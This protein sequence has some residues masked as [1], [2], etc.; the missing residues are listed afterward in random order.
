M[1]DWEWFW[2]R[3]TD[4]KGYEHFGPYP[5]ALAAEREKEREMEKQ[6]P[7]PLCSYSCA[8][9]MPKLEEV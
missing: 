5:S 6:P 3:Y 2:A 8:Y 9:F 4:E 7:S 1:Q